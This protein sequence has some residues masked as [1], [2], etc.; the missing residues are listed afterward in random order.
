MP[1]L[2]YA[3]GFVPTLS[4]SLYLLVAYPLSLTLLM[5]GNVL[6]GVFL[7]AHSLIVAAY[8]LHDLMHNSVFSEPRHNAMLGRFV[9]FLV[10]A[11]VSPYER[12]REKHFRHHFERADILAVNYSAFLTRHSSLDRA[13]KVA[14]WCGFPAVELLCK[15]LE[16]R[17]GLTAG[18]K[19][20]LRVIRVLSVRALLFMALALLNPM[21]PFYY[22]IGYLLF[23][24]CLAFMDAFQHSYELRYEL[25][26]PQK[27]S[28][29]DRGYEEKNTYSN[30]IST[31]FPRLN[32]LILNFSY[33][34]AHHQKPSEPWYRLP[35]HHRQL[36][37][38]SCPQ[39]VPLR[40]QIRQ[41]VQHRLNR[42]HHPDNHKKTGTDGVSFL[43]GV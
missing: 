34:N 36:Y 20:R 40:T 17:E 14:V 29:F 15:V 11:S 31:R 7:L 30:L 19:A 24:Q 9:A 42:I 23:L 35:A 43:V 8:F 25:T 21:A 27:A 4:V 32:L 1:S 12:L 2:K 33:H 13:V 37:H 10:G 16:I 3:D 39:Q 26:Q 6:F 38:Q 18:G 5:Q 41:F 22:L 28:M